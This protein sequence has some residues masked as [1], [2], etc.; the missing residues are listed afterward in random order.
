MNNTRIETAAFI[1]R[2]GRALGIRFW[3]DSIRTEVY[4]LKPKDLPREIWHTFERACGG[5]LP[6]IV[7]QLEAENEQ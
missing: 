7:A 5:Y 6:E 4:M 1:L 3:P 2:E